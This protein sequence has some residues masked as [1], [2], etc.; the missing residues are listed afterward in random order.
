MNWISTPLWIIPPK[1]RDLFF[2][3]RQ[4]RFWM[5]NFLRK[6][7]YSTWCK[8]WGF[9]SRK[10]KMGWESL[11]PQTVVWSTS[12]DVLESSASLHIITTLPNC[13]ISMDFVGLKISSVVQFRD[14]N[15]LQAQFLAVGSQHDRWL[16]EHLGIFQEGE[17]RQEE[18]RLID[19]F[20]AEFDT[21]KEKYN[22]P[23]GVWNWYEIH[24]SP[25]L[26]AT[27]RLSD[28]C[29]SFCVFPASV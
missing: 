29:R 1:R 21:W 25:H 23:T 28:S 13:W 12:I 3:T 9:R 10:R 8:K 15:R 22:I 7:L 2:S 20:S 24:Q 6:R 27:W 18:C 5:W 19:A 14:F 11:L 17:G 26:G 16:W 4:K